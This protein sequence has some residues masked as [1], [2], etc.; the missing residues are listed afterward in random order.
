M[1][2]LGVRQAEDIAKGVGQARDVHTPVR[3]P[4]PM[5]AQTGGPTRPH[6]AGPAL[7]PRPVRGSAGRAKSS[8]SEGGKFC[9]A[10]APARERWRGPRTPPQ[11]ASPWAEERSSKASELTERS[12]RK[13]WQPLSPTVVLRWRKKPFIAIG[14]KLT[15]LFLLFLASEGRSVRHSRTGAGAALSPSRPASATLCHLSWSESLWRISV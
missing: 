10:S 14:I 3:G 5:A 13:C 11:G 9:G 7:V 1:L 6:R 8:R 4:R 12:P 15:C 2:K